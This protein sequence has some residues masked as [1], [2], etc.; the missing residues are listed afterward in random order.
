[1]RV[2]HA[3]RKGLQGSLIVLL[4]TCSLHA[5]AADSHYRWLDSRGNTVLSDRPPPA[6]IDYEV[7]STRSGF[8]RVVKS[9]EGAVPR[10]VV[11]STRNEF[12]PVDRTATTATEK[13]SEYCQRARENL[14]ALNTAGRIRVRNDQGEP[15]Y[16]NEEQ[17]A[18]E[19]RIAEEAIRLYCE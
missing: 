10:E 6:G 11:P 9:S 3:F 13:N 12:E 1:M 4:A 5:A 15:Q 17:I 18:G 2:Q 7:I 19:K 16:L 8:K 14:E